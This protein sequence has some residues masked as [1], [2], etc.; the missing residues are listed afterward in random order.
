EDGS[1][2]ELAR[3]DRLL[4]HER[5]VVR[6]GGVQ[7]HASTPSPLGGL[8]LEIL[9]RALELV[10]CLRLQRLGV[11]DQT[12][13]LATRPL[14]LAQGVPRCEDRLIG[15]LQRLVLRDRHRH[16]L[17]ALVVTALAEKGPGLA[18]ALRDVEALDG[19][20][21]LAV[22][23]LPRRRALASPVRQKASPAEWT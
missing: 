15:T 7:A 17:L 4:D 20:P 21:H 12:P 22:Q 2:L 3:D 13:G 18:V 9:L 5:D 10:V 14:R 1:R 16:P 19:Y 8:L 11:F 6:L 23:F